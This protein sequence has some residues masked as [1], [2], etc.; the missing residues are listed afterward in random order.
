MKSTDYIIDKLEIFIKKFPQIRVRY[1]Y[2][3]STIVHTIEVIPNKVYH[4]NK[5]YIDWES[6]VFDE[7][8]ENFPYE[9]ICFISDYDSYGIENE[10]FSK[11]GLEFSQTVK[12]KNFIFNRQTDVT[13]RIVLNGTFTI[14][15][16]KLNNEQYITQE[17][18]HKYLLA[19]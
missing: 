6:K 19:A 2:N 16:R 12:G 8:I 15:D 18:S 14:L 1:E 9:N 7:F 11:E 17:Y 5:E 10:M 3:E 13:E 4:S